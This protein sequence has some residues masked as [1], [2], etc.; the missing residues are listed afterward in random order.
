M[1]LVIILLDGLRADTQAFAAPPEGHPWHRFLP[2]GRRFTQMFAE[3]PLSLPA[4]RAL[5]TGRFQF[6]RQG[7]TP[8]KDDAVTFLDRLSDTLLVGDTP[9]MLGERWHLGRRFTNVEHVRGQFGD[10]A[11]PPARIAPELEETLTKLR[12]AE[13]AQDE[14]EKF[15]AY[16]AHWAAVSAPFSERVVDRALA[17]MNAARVTWIDLFDTHEPWLPRHSDVAT[18]PLPH[19]SLKIANAELLRTAYELQ[20]S[21]T[22]AQVC[23]V[24]TALEADV[25]AGACAVCVLSDHGTPLGDPQWRKLQPTVLAPIAHAAAWLWAK[26]VAPGED[27]RLASTVDWHPTFRAL[28]GLDHAGEG[29]SLLAQETH[30]H[31]PTGWIHGPLALRTATRT[32]LYTPGPLPTLRVFDR[33][34]DPLERTPLKLATQDAADALSTLL[35][36]T[37]RYAGD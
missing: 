13:V 30:A 4:R 19:P 14:R 6:A 2:R 11:P 8:L 1:R 21:E 10:D 12:A 31:V 25:A 37:L 28:L 27:A 9:Y 32:T 35:Q 15:H 16:L 20:A 22:L 3:A 34:R 5:L 33:A 24:L 7:W 23:R 17:R 36:T 18:T 29:H 26:D